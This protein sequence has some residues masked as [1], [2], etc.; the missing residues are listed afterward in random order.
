MKVAAGGELE[1]IADKLLKFIPALADLVRTE[2]KPIVGVRC[3]DDVSDAV[4][5]GHFRHF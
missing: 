1:A 4:L 3:A 2:F 5:D